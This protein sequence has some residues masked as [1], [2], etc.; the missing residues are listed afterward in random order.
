MKT[1]RYARMDGVNKPP[2]PMA[3][4]RRVSVKGTFSQCRTLLR[5]MPFLLGP[6]VPHDLEAWKLLMDLIILL[7]LICAYHLAPDMIEML[8]SM[9]EQWLKDFRSLFP[10]FK[11]TP[12][13]HFL[14][15]CKHWIGKIGPLRR[16]WTMRFEASGIQNYGY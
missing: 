6:H 13:F 16:A 4:G 14:L 8:Q 11:R 10:D 15:H 12:K 9:T 5:I 3:K 7:Q 2:A 1:F